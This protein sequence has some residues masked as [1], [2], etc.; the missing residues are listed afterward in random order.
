MT[1]IL[2]GTGFVSLGLR[3]PQA[4]LLSPSKS[5]LPPS[6]LTCR[7]RIAP[8]DAVCHCPTKLQGALSAQRGHVWLTS[9]HLKGIRQLNPPSR[10]GPLAP[11][12]PESPRSAWRAG[13][14]GDRP[15]H[16]WGAP[17][18]ARAQGGPSS[19]ER[20]GSWPGR[21][22]WAAGHPSEGTSVRRG[23]EPPAGMVGF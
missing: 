13:L 9:D 16:P 7:Q 4:A 21:V 23:N 14:P 10:R 20:R 12:P 11:S 6:G 18:E 5:R 3:E 8:L 1:S 15:G 22:L 17:P 19:T 2:C